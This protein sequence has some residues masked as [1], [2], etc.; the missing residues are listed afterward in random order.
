MF[1][2]LLVLPAIVAPVS[3]TAQGNDPFLI[4]LG[5]AQD[6]GYPHIG[7]R[8][9]CCAPAIGKPE[10][11]KK[12]TSLGLVDPVSRQVWLLE[13]TPD[14]PAQLSY[15]EKTV[16]GFEVAN[17]SGIFLTHG[18]IGHYTGLMYLGREAMG[19]KAIPVYAMPRMNAYLKTNGPWSLLDSLNNIAIQPITARPIKLNER[20]TVTPFL[21]P[22][23]DEF[24]ETVGF[25]ITT[26]K[27]SVVFMPDVDKWEK[28]EEDIVKII[29]KADYALLDGTFYQANELPGRNMSDIPH[30]FIVES[31]DL[32]KTLSKEEKAKVHFIH[33]NH[34]NPV[35][36]KG[37]ARE[38]IISKGFKV[39]TEGQVIEL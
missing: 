18:H 9:S 36:Q 33:F 25:T 24:T 1:C 12:V 37:K 15:L 3:G 31:M 26:Q 8:D 10:M 5:V 35:M 29:R 4:V 14:M 22:H 20:I 34:S 28:W 32:F 16:K 7:C 23:R 19:T 39:A 17:L 11:R 13:A 2:L 38:E 27:A 21:V 6:A 30:P